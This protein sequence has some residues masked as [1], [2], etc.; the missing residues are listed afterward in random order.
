MVIAK[1]S[2]PCS[3]CLILI[4]KFRFPKSSF[5][6]YFH[7]FKLQ[8]HKIGQNF[9]PTVTSS[10]LRNGEKYHGFTPDGTISKENY[11]FKETNSSIIQSA[12]WVHILVPNILMN[13]GNIGRNINT[14]SIIVVNFLFLVPNII[15]PNETLLFHP[16]TVR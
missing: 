2:C 3:S 4:L 5:L 13:I 1:R 6:S 8:Y 7:A 16:H 12:S 9:P 11:K 14:I 10:S 15:V